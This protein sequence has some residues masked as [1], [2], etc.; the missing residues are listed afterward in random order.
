M[1]TFTIDCDNNITTFDSLKEATAA[2]IAGAEYFGSQKELAQL[3]ASWPS[4]RLIEV[5]NS[6]PGVVPVKKFKD[7][8]TACGRIWAAL[9]PKEATVG[10]QARQDA[11]EAARTP[12][13]ASTG[14]KRPPR[15]RAGRRPSRAR[16]PPPRARAA[17]T[18]VRTTLAASS[19]WR[20]RI[21][22]RLLS[23]AGR[24]GFAPA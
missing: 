20:M 7:R 6:L 19:I 17:P 24:R 9:A 4:N 23:H 21:R 3:A 1:T 13:K 11:P 5:W 8:K 10:A 2:D 15:A 14:G 22:S 16:K 18:R 12:K